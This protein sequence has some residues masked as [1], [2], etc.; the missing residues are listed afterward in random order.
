LLLLSGEV[1][2]AYSYPVI[3]NPAIKSRCCKYNT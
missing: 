3:S 2:R 1:E